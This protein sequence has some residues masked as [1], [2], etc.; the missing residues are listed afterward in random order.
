MKLTWLAVDIKGESQL[1]GNK[2]VKFEGKVEDPVIYRN[3][4]TNIL[5]YFEI[6][7]PDQLLCYVPNKHYCE[8]EGTILLTR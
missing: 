3:Y 5:P 1:I 7:A 6:L 4:Q 8:S 2:A